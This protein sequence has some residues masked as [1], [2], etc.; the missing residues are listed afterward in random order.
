M[1]PSLP[2]EH[3]TLGAGASHAALG[4]IPLS[5]VQLLFSLD[6]WEPFPAAPQP[7]T[8]LLG[9]VPCSVQLQLWFQRE[10]VPSSCT[11]VISEAVLTNTSQVPAGDTPSL[12]P[13]PILTLQGVFGAHLSFRLCLVFSPEDAKCLFSLPSSGISSQQTKHSLCAKLAGSS[14]SWHVASLAF[15]PD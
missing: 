6:R 2:F 1:G 8:L 5:L 11:T 3:L 13:T 10:P 14:L 4:C 12:S 9:T 15:H 7:S